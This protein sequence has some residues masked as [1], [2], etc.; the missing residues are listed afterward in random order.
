MN[1]PIHILYDMPSYWIGITFLIF[2][3]LINLQINVQINSVRFWYKAQMSCNNLIE[4][5][6]YIWICL[7][8]YCNSKSGIVS[9][10]MSS[11]IAQT[12]IGLNCG[13]L[14][15]ID[16]KES[17]NT[18][19]IKRFRRKARSKTFYSKDKISMVSDELLLLYFVISD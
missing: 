2:V 6:G 9:I 15:V 17:A 10:I 13:K 8:F 1:I 14:S 3:Q 19:L 12:L 16:Y 4:I 18:H 5:C 7:W 11:F